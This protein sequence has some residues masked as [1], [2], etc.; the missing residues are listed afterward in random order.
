MHTVFEFHIKLI[1]GV[2]Y[3][4]AMKKRLILSLVT[5]LLFVF[6]PVVFVF[7]AEYKLATEEDCKLLENNGFKQEC[8]P[9]KTLMSDVSLSLLGSECSVNGEDP[10]SFLLKRLNNSSSHVTQLNTGFACCLARFVN[11]AEQS[12]H[13]I[14]IRSGYRSPQRQA[15]LK[16]TKGKWAGSPGGW[17]GGV[18]QGSR[19]NCGIAADLNFNGTH[20]GASLQNCMN[21][22]A[23]KWAHENAQKFGLLF[24]LLGGCGKNNGQICEPW[25]VEPMS[26]S[27]NSTC[28]IGSDQRY[29]GTNDTNTPALNQNGTQNLQGF[30]QGTGNPNILTPDNSTQYPNVAQNGNNQILSDDEIN[31]YI[32]NYFSSDQINSEINDDTN[33]QTDD[34][35]KSAFTLTEDKK[36]LLNNN[37]EN[38]TLDA[39][40]YSSIQSNGI[41]ERSTEN[42]NKIRQIKQEI[43][44]KYLS[45]EIPKTPENTRLVY[46]ALNGTPT[47]QKQAMLQ[48]K[49]ILLSINDSHK[50]NV[51][52]ANNFYIDP[53]SNESIF[54]L[55]EKDYKQRKSYYLNYT[56]WGALF[57]VRKNNDTVNIKNSIESLFMNNDEE[58]NISIWSIIWER[59]K[60]MF[61]AVYNI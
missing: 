49:E 24:R 19:H 25:H 29:A 27:Q 45:G 23:C 34:A 50:R 60:N 55:S 33:I 31:E 38:G 53:A 9:G 37:R 44:S 21:N 58:V 22:P 48:L 20:V 18:C 7:S 46:V 47:Q 8:I 12:G 3:Y 13:K 35:E 39:Q 4:L 54:N 30:G 61:I 28:I 52:I 5:G 51:D 2:C 59:I 17:V 57:S 41:N 26:Q 1:I 11:S 36:E 16:A 14:T 10:K 42:E 40:E 56:P 32:R 6:V 15:Q 43:V